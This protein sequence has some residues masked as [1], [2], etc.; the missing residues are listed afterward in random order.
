MT[1]ALSMTFTLVLLLVLRY[2]DQIKVVSEEYREAKNLVSG[3]IVGFKGQLRQ[4]EEKVNDLN[5]EI[6]LLRSIRISDIKSNKNNLTISDLEKLEQRIEEI[7]KT[8]EH[9]IQEITEIRKLIEGLIENQKDIEKHL[10]TLDERYRGLLPETEAEQI[11]PVKTNVLQ[12]QLHTTELEILQTLITEGDMSAT[13][14]RNRIGR[15][16][17]HVARL[18]KKLHEQGLVERDERKRPY[19]YAASKKIKETEKR[20][21]QETS[22]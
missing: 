6:L 13:E 1:I 18:M 17:E 19:K 22:D 11:I 4:H 10:E 16:R 5:K 8:N 21:V 3:V 15:S 9:P 14:I 7:Q 20:E 2:Y 12:P